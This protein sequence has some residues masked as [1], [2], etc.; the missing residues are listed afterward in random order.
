MSEI[1]E[2]LRELQSGE[3][4]VISSFGLRD[5]AKQVRGSMARFPYW[6]KDIGKSCR[7]LI[8]TTVYI[9]F[10]ALTGENPEFTRE[11]P[12]MPIGSYTSIVLAL[13]RNADMNDKVKQLFLRFT[14]SDM[15]DT[16]DYDVITDEDKQIFLP[17]R[18]VQKFSQ[19]VIMANLKMLSPITQKYSVVPN[20]DPDSGIMRPEKG[21]RYATW[22]EVYRLFNSLIQ[23]EIDE[24][25]AEV[26]AKKIT[27]ADG[28]TKKTTIR[29]KI[30]VSSD[31]P[32]NAIAVLLLPQGE[33]QEI[34]KDIKLDSIT[35]EKIQTLMHSF[36]EVVSMRE[37]LGRFT[38]GGKQDRFMDFIEM[39]VM[40]PSDLSY[41]GQPQLIAGKTAYEITPSDFS[42][43]SSSKEELDGLI[44]AYRDWLDS[45]KD[46]ERYMLRSMKAQPFDVVKNEFLDAV[47]MELDSRDSRL[48]TKIVKSN[49]PILRD[50]FAADIDYIE[51][52]LVSSD[53]SDVEEQQKVATEVAEVGRKF[54]L[55]TL[56]TEDDDKKTDAGKDPFGSEE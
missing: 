15:W 40:C 6:K 31:M 11:T 44:V 23:P 24:V 39:S 49:L 7:I 17:F 20:R 51:N 32:Y 16:T 1:S 41:S 52:L 48:T 27:E 33:N 34:S 47:A 45:T 13:K 22:Y 28:R 29:Q 3:R 36:D 43:I 37:A 21:I 46:L 38:F 50:L 53:L 54:D 8:P 42:I 56:V 19:T 30:L 5:P 18:R 55:E 26:I 9:P 12:F 25:D 10:D 4:S 14:G 2:F 35:K